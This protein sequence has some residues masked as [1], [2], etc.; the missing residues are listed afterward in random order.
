MT[1]KTLYSIFRSSPN[2]Q[3]VMQYPNVVL[4]YQFIRTHRIKRILDLGTGIGASAAICA[5]ALKD[6][7]E[8]DYQ[9]DS[10]EQYDKCINLAKQLIPLEL[11][12]HLTIHKTKPTVWSY[13]QIPYHF[14]SNYE[15]LP[16]G[17]WDL[18]IND[19]PTFWEENDAL[20][21][22]PNGTVTQMLLDGRIKPGTF[23][24]WDG[25]QSMLL[26]LE[27]FFGSDDP[28]ESS[29]ELYRAN[30]T[31]DDFN[32]LRRLETPIKCA[33]YKLTMMKRDTTFFKNNEITP[34]LN[35]ATPPR[36]HEAPVKRAT[37]TLR[38]R[39]L[40]TQTKGRGYDRERHPVRD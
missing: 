9:I 17:E 11:Q 16:D 8:T 18:I 14:F 31:G 37:K 25:R 32:I 23:V 40:G 19:G 10:L 27:R 5:L 21:D 12:E 38:S 15:T 34:T 33:D 35:R 29:F 4:L 6:K 7:G 39:S 30:Q 26:I 1:L 2:G 36:A 20:V 3:W 13:P 28:S 22:L 24:A